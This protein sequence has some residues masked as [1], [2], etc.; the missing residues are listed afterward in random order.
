MLPTTSKAG[1]H[2]KGGKY[3]LVLRKYQIVFIIID[4]WFIFGSDEALA[5]VPQSTNTGWHSGSLVNRLPLCYFNSGAAIQCQAGFI[6]AE[7]EKHRCP[8]HCKSA[9]N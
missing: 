8:A 5:S 1:Y 7:T 2:E 3:R 6:H 9:E 4:P